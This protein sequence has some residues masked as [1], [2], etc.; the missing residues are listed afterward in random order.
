ME[1]WEFWRKRRKTE[2]T[3]KSE[4]V[5]SP[6]LVSLQSQRP[7]SPSKPSSPS[8]PTL[9]EK[10]LRLARSLQLLQS[11]I[12]LAREGIESLESRLEAITHASTA[13]QIDSERRLTLRKAR[14]DPPPAITNPGPPFSLPQTGTYVWIPMGHVWLIGL[15]WVILGTLA[16]LSLWVG[17][18]R[19]VVGMRRWE[20]YSFGDW[21]RDESWPT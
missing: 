5:S 11:D 7:P 14:G 3:V 16:G 10:R 18:E 13:R 17:Y 12:R 4:A 19:S 6:Q 9:S 20:P 8:L 1:W 15:L 2:E 21:T